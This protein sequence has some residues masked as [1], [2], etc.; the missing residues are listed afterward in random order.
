MDTEVNQSR[1]IN[2]FL[3]HAVVGAASVIS[4]N[5]PFADR[6]QPEDCIFAEPGE[7]IDCLE[8][9]LADR[10]RMLDM[11]NQ[12]RKHAQMISEEA[13]T[14]QIDF[15]KERLPVINNDSHTSDPQV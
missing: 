8:L 15:W 6:L 10:K 1:S 4:T 7:W 3:E 12:A 11:A 13:R 14:R 5:A 2:K 9:L